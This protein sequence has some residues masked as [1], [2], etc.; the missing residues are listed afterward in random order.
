M[1]FKFLTSMLIAFIA[2][3]AASART[4]VRQDSSWQRI[5]PVG[6]SFTVSMPKPA[7]QD[8]RLI[9]LN[10]NDRIPAAI[11]Q[12]ITN[13]KRFIAAELYRQTSDV[14]PMSSY[15]K[16]TAGMVHTFEAGNGANSIIFLRDLSFPG[17]TG[18]EYALRLKDYSGVIAA[19]A[20]DGPETLREAAVRAASLSR[21]TPTELPA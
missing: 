15:E 18:K 7:T 9:S 14:R 3:N 10:D 1:I 5:A 2:A 16:F 11:F 21:F 17:L 13:G 20:L 12:V 4:I 19:K 6:R 8:F